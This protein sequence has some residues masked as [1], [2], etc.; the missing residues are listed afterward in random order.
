MQLRTKIYQARA[1]MIRR[2]TD[3]KR[4]NYHRY[5]GRGITVCAE[6]L[7][8]FE[9]FYQWSLL[10]G[11]GIN[12]SLDRINTNGNYCP[13]NCRWVDI[14]IQANNTRTNV[15]IEHNGERLTYAQWEERI[16]GCKGLIWNRINM[17]WSE[18]DAVTISPKKTWDRRKKQSADVD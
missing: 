14:K 11:V 4:H 1:D 15:F 18:A 13:D 6:W 3:V 2:C 7:I 16:G 17:G 5:G 12:L 9:S 10:N 8:S